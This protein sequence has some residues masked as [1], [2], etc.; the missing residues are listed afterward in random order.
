MPRSRFPETL[1]L[2]IVTLLA[3]STIVGCASDKAPPPAPPKPLSGEQILR[4]S[5]GMAQLGKRYQE[6]EALVRKGDELVRQG[7]ARITEGERLIE[8]GKAIMRESEQGYGEL[9]K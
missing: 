7:Q 1:T 5:E 4:E 2:K 8:Q 6:G 9:K 3:A